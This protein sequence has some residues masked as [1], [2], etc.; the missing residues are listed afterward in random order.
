MNSE[1]D[2]WRMYIPPA[3]EANDPLAIIRRYPFAMFVTADEDGH[4]FATQIPIHPELGVDGQ[5]AHLIGH[6]AKSN[7][8]AK[9]LKDGMPAL[10]V[11]SGPHAYISS[12]WYVEMPT[13]P[14]WNYV[15]AQVRGTLTVMDGPEDQM[16]VLE[17]VVSEAE[18]AN[19]SQWTMAD[20]PEGK[21]ETLMP[22]IRSFRIKIDRIDGKA[23][24]SQTHPASDRDR[25]AAALDRR[26][27][28]GDREISAMIKALD[29]G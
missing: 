28:P 27:F 4:S 7:P 9:M 20:A 8:Q 1:R 10:A 14:T 12:T 26:D 13:V 21:V 22:H 5:P 18:R 6:L 17:R 24:L 25:I 2:D 23:K 29:A 19:G 3:Y 15:T 11:F 16:N